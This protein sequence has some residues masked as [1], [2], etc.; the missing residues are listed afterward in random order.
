MAKKE[1]VTII[2]SDDFDEVDE[3]LSQ[4]LD[5]LELANARVVNLLESEQRGPETS[6]LFP[7]EMAESAEDTPDA[8][9][10]GAD[11]KNQ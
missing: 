7:E 2:H 11:D 1:K 4:A 5:G 3:A 8:A 9:D 6:E 10:D